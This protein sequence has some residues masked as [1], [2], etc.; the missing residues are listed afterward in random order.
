M[1]PLS[2]QQIAWRAA[3]LT[4]RVRGAFTAPEATG[5]LQVDG[6]EASGATASRLTADIQG[7]F[8]DTYLSCK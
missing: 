8:K 6:L 2:R 4:A 3:S 7:K 5:R 1:K